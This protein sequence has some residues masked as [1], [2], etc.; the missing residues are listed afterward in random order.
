MAQSAYSNAY[1]QLSAE[2][3][4]FANGILSN[5]TIQLGSLAE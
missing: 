5:A 3:T 2:W 1:N 4:D